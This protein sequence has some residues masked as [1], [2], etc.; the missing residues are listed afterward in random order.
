MESI[1]KPMSIEEI[2]V[3][4]FFNGSFVYSLNQFSM[5]DLRYQITKN[6]V[7]G[8]TFKMNPQ[9]WRLFHEDDRIEDFVGI[10]KPNG[11]ISKWFPKYDASEEYDN[12]A[13]FGEALA[14]VI[15]I[16]TAQIDREKDKNE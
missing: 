6:A 16:R 12:I 7:E 2:V 9:F 10:I 3:D 5:L 13:V 8:Y 11:E 4:I 14:A 15:K 1:I